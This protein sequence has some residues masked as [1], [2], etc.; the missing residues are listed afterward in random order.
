MHMQISYMMRDE[1]LLIWTDALGL[2]I[3]ERDMKLAC[4]GT[5][6]IAG[7]NMHSLVQYG[8]YMGNTKSILGS[9]YTPLVL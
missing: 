4:R 3:S 5:L 6:N 1:N 7:I 9:L 8:K 2:R